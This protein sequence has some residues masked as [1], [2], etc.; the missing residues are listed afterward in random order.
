LD[1]IPYDLRLD[2]EDVISMM[3]SDL[4]DRKVELSLLIDSDVPTKLIGDSDRVNQV[5]MNL[6]ANAIKFTDDGSINVHVSLQEDSGAQAELMVRVTDTGI[7][8]TPEITR[9]IFN[10]FH[11][12]DASISR[13]YGGTGL[14]LSIVSK[15]IELWD[16]KIGVESESGKGSAFWFTLRSLKQ[17]IRDDFPVDDDIKGRK[18]LLY[19]EHL[20]AL[21]AVRN[22]LLAWSINVYQARS[23]RQIQP[24]ID[25]AADDGEPYD[26]IIIGCE[27]ESAMR[28][29]AASASTYY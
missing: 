17:D 2:F 16:G 5:L 4:A 28:K 10:P 13:R 9:N 7:G 3:S 21:R 20:P 22:L 8:M 26:L 27:R 23:R 14:G 25:I 6:L 12:G 18:V 15:L 24:M 19:D 29:P 11:Q 1:Q